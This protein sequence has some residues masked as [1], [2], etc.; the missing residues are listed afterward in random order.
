MAG[1]DNRSDADRDAAVAA[2]GAECSGDE[3]EYGNVDDSMGAFF[4]ANVWF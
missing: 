2:Y 4:G 3:P 1:I